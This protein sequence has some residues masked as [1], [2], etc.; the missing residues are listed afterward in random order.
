MHPTLEI[1]LIDYNLA[2]LIQQMLM[3]GISIDVRRG[4]ILAVWIV[5]VLLNVLFSG[6]KVYR[7]GFLSSPSMHYWMTFTSDGEF[8]LFKFCVCT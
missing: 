7:I 6:K 3:L 2:V 5:T 8:V 4:G 1:P